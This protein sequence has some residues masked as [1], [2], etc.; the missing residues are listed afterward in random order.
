MANP[1][2]YRAPAS[3]NAESPAKR[4]FQICVSFLSSQ[5]HAF[6]ALSH[7]WKIGGI[8]ALLVLTLGC[9]WRAYYV[10]WR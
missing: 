9:R 8:L 5:F 10:A 1:K 7:K 4:L 2:S 3:D 6:R